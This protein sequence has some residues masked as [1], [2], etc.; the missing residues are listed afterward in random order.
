MPSWGYQRHTG[1]PSITTWTA[2]PALRHVGA[3]RLSRGGH[4]NNPR[5]LSGVMLPNHAP[6]VIA[7]QFRH[8]PRFYPGRID[9]GLGRAPGTDQ[10]TMR[11]LRRTRW[12]P[13]RR[14]TSLATWS[15]SRTS[16]RRPITPP[17]AP[18]PASDV[19]CQFG[20]S[21]PVSTAH[22]WQRNLGYPFAFASHFAPAMLMQ[23][24]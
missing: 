6:L 10:M 8:S 17:G 4:E 11:A 7:E 20:C 3:D 5:W 24:R 23:A 22:R 13:E 14:M 19:T 21:A 2:W 12:Q 18:F 1:S 16:N 9:L 15:S